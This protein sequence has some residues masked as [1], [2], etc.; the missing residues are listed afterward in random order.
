MCAADLLELRADVLG[1]RDLAPRIAELLH[2]ATVGS[3]DRKPPFPEVPRRDDENPVAGRACVGDRGIHSARARSRVEQDVA[4]SPVDLLERRQ[5]LSE[6]GTKA[7]SSVMDDREGHGREYR[8]RHRSRPG[9]HQVALLWHPGRE[10]SPCVRSRRGSPPGLRRRAPRATARRRPRRPLPDNA[11]P[12]TGGLVC[13]AH[14]L[15]DRLRR[16]RGGSGRRLE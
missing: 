15:C 6:H 13:F 10:V 7:R 12:G 11:A 5:E 2:V 4:G 14:R 16:A 1:A 8:R 9:R 3:S